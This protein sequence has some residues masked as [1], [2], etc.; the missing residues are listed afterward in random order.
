MISDKLVPRYVIHIPAFP[1]VRKD[2]K[3]ALRISF[4]RLTVTGKNKNEDVRIKIS[5]GAILG[6][7]EIVVPSEGVSAL[8]H[9]LVHLSYNS[10]GSSNFRG[11]IRAEFVSC[12]IQIIGY[13]ADRVQKYPKYLFDPGQKYLN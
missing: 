3:G 9:H 13:I 2:Q 10:L 4:Y 6:P 11:G 7:W 5:G 8:G 12:I 1:V